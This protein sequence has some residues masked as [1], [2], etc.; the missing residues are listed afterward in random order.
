VAGVLPGT[1]AKAGGVLVALLLVVGLVAHERRSELRVFPRSAYL[2]DSPLKWV[3]LTL[4]LLAFGV[5]VESFLPLFG[6]RLGGLAPL[7]A[8]FFGAAIS[9]GWVVAQIRSSSVV[10]QSGIRRL[11]AIGPGL[12]A[13][14]LLALG[15]LQQDDAPIWLVITWVP[16]LFLAGCG[17][18]AAYPHLSVAAMADGE[19]AAAAVATVT[20]LSMAFGAAVAGVLLN[21]GD[22]M[23]DSARYLLFGF[24]VIC[25]LGIFTACA[26]NKQSGALTSSRPRPTSGR[27]R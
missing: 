26:S 25:A 14:G 1:A 9:L 27:R 4:G 11:R 15:L 10:R 7:A 18:G 22:S 17:I 5:A 24:A 16:V 2:P 19:Q 23:L 8:G 20:T 6:Q 13:L 3:Y 12:L 21:M